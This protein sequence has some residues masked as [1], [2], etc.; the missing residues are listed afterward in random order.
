MKKKVIGLLMLICC[1]V[2]CQ[3]HTSKSYTFNVETGDTI[4]IELETG[5]GYDLLQEDGSFT[6]KKDDETILQGIF[7]TEDMLDQYENAVE[8]DEDVTMKKDY[9]D[10]IYYEYDGQTGQEYNFIVKVKESQTGLLIG[11]TTGCQEAQEAFQRLS[12]EKR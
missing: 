9:H 5:D 12:F 10:Y 1:L 2:G 11:S 6:V 4:Q 3:T 7:L 8:T